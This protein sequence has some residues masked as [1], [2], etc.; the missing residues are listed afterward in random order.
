MSIH[1]QFVKT[2]KIFTVAMCVCVC[3]VVLIYNNVRTYTCM[4]VRISDLIVVCLL[5]VISNNSL[6][7]SDPVQVDG[8]TFPRPPVPIILGFSSETVQIQLTL[9]FNHRFLNI[10]VE[11]SIIAELI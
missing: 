10:S 6:G 7:V 1:E 4:Y 3:M 11:V 9:L 5:K 8:F 2:P